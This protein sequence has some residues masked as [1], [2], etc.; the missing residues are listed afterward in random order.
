MRFVAH[1][2]TSRAGVL[3]FPQYPIP[4]TLGQYVQHEYTRAQPSYP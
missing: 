1:Q 4:I 3:A 2:V